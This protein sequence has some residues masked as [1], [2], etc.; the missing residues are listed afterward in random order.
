MR[1]KKMNR[2]EFEKIYPCIEESEYSTPYDFDETI[3]CQDIVDLI[4][5]LSFPDTKNL[6]PEVQKTIYSYMN[7]L[8]EF[9]KMIYDEVR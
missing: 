4:D 5:S 8:M 9:K 3:E 6:T 1:I 7:K 2:A